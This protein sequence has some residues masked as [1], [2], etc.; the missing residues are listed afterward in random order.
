MIISPSIIVII[1]MWCN[2]RNSFKIGYYEQKLQN[3][4]V[5]IFRVRTMPWYKLWLN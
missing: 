2:I 5:E 3:R 1:L 4:G